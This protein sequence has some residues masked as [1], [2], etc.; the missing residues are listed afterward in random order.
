MIAGFRSLDDCGVHKLRGLRGLDPKAY[1]IRYWSPLNG[2]DSRSKKTEDK[3]PLE[4]FLEYFKSMNNATD[5]DDGFCDIDFDHIKA[6]SSLKNNKACGNDMVLNEFLKHSKEQ[7]LSV[8]TN[9]FNLVTNFNNS[10]AANPDKYSLRGITM[11]TSS[12]IS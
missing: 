11:L 7:F 6:I 12:E 2:T 10:D 9:N 5:T 3:V 8:Y 4:V 1:L